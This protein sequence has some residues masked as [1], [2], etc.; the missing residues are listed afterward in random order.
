MHIQPASRVTP[1]LPPSAARP[2]EAV[3]SRPDRSS[4]GA[5]LEAPGLIPA[6][7]A[8]PSAS[9]VVAPIA[10]HLLQTPWLTQGLDQ[11]YSPNHPNGMTTRV[12]IE[13]QLQMVNHYVGAETAN[14]QRLAEADYEALQSMVAN[15]TAPAHLQVS[16]ADLKSFFEPLRQ[17]LSPSD[18]KVL[19]VVAGLHDLGKMSPEWAQTSGLNLE[20]VEW[21]AHDF[22]TETLLKNNP[23]LLQPYQLDEQEQ[24]KVELLCRLHSLP[25]QYFF[26][27]GNPAAY[28][29]LF[30]I[31][32]QEESENVLSLA[33]IH[34]ALDVMS[35]LNHKFVKPI[36]DSHVRLKD[37]ISGAYAQSTPLGVGFRQAATQELEENPAFSK[38]GEQFDLGPVAL[39]RLRRLVG[40]GIPAETF[41]SAL[42]GLDR[43]FVQE[44]QRC[45][46]GESTW[47][48]TYVANAFGSGLVK[49]LKDQVPAE[50]AIQ[51][52]VKMVAS[53]SHF[54]TQKQGRAQWALGSLEPSLQVAAGPEQAQQILSET[55]QL[56]HLEQAV[57]RLQSGRHGLTMRAGE[58]GVEIG[59]QAITPA[60]PQE[61]TWQLAPRA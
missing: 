10:A 39:F 51:A 27:E 47:F 2:A 37:F 34:G 49:A 11:A 21:I 44:F 56:T 12:H 5:H 1:A 22:D 36:L 7:S 46:D 3:Q 14:L 18:W 58:S 20:G 19:T 23:S 16:A 26:G 25:G 17:Q 4:L 55:R 13:H 42:A 9:Q 60:E 15:S 30:A 38:L 48:G 50:E 29:P 28:G 59:F 41:T 45:S 32:Q 24:T 54:H 61:P 33:R 8:V 6:P 31:A 40:T 57:E 52:T 43:S 53:A 35:A